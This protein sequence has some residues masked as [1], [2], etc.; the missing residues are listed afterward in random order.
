MADARG[1][2]RNWWILVI[3]LSLLL[4]AG[5]GW[6]APK[7]RKAARQRALVKAV[8]EQGGSVEYYSTNY[9]DE[10][11]PP[12]DWLRSFL[13]EDFYDRLSGV[14]LHN[15]VRTDSVLAQLSSSHAVC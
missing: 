3:V 11:L 2:T 4:C 1:S 8:R 5:L 6:F 12:P 10:N 15:G 13:G 9:T 7:A 14:T